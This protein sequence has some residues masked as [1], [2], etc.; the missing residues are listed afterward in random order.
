MAATLTAVVAPHNPDSS[1]REIIV[2]GTIV[3]SG[4]YGTAN[5]HG[6]T[7][8][9]QQLQDAVKSSQLPTQ[10]E[11]YEA[12]PAGTA[13]SF[14]QFVF[15]PGTSQLNGVLSIGSN[16]TEFTQGN[17]YSTSP[18]LAAAVIKVC[19]WFPLY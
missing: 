8:N 3:L 10:V 4:N 2:Y 5:S 17:A 11:I 12:P 7:L 15:C 14:Y 13:P 18:A 19:A 1:A 16:L 9:L 6:D